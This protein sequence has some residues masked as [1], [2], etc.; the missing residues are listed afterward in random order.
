MRSRDPEEI[1]DS[2]LKQ[3]FPSHEYVITRVVRE[4]NGSGLSL[5]FQNEIGKDKLILSFQPTEANL[6]NKAY[7][8]S[9]LFAVPFNCLDN[10]IYY[11]C[12]F[13]DSCNLRNRA[14]KTVR[15]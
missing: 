8:R 10:Y 9:V 11:N 2:D 4:L 13:V 5:T 12:R 7:R 1:L 14:K 6:G 15:E 3:S